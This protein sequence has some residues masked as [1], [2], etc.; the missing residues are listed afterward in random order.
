MAVL[1]SFEAGPRTALR[2]VMTVLGVALTVY[3]VYLLRKP[4][5]WLVVAAFL[6][7]AVGGPVRRLEG[8]MPR[9][10]AIAIVYSAVICIPIALGALLIP[11]L[12]NQ[13]EDLVNNV[14]GYVDDFEKF[15]NDNDTLKK[16]N[17][18]Y[19]ITAKLQDEAAKLPSHIGTATDT[20]SNIGVGL[21]NSIFAAVTILILSIFMVSG[22]SGWIERFLAAQDPDHRERLRRTLDRIGEAIG[23]YVGG[24][25]IQATLAGV[26]AYV[27]LAILGAPFAGA[28]ALVVAF[29]DLIPVVGATIAAALV[30]IVMLFVNFPVGVIVWVIYALIY[31]QVEN[32]LIQPQ[33]QR[34]AV[35][36]EPFLILVAVLF[37]STLFGV[38]GAVLAI[39][40]AATI[41]ISVR[42]FIDYRRE[43]A[44]APTVAVGIGPSPPAAEPA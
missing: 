28:L 42:E 10:A 1:R 44:A 27:V 2:T 32:Y 38:G 6:A 5:S 30:A 14:P 17:E 11:P 41:Q 19:D 22:G 18:D 16:L 29:G 8:R 21:V 35:A 20:L 9:G 23:N 37:G 43:L 13:A 36:V 3:V 4:I 40:A 33:I 12:V 7:V 39:P 26:T 34:R 31:Q 24:A 15:V 25:L